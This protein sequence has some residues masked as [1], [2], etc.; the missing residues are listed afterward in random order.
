MK[1]LI[2]A[3]KEFVDIITSKRFIALLIAMIIFFLMS[4]LQTFSATRISMGTA[5]GFF[6]GSG[7]AFI[8]GIFG[9]ALGFDL[10]T[11]EKESGTLRTLLTHPLFRDEIIIGKTIAGFLAICLAVFVTMLFMLGAMVMRYIPSFDE[12]LSLAKLMLVTIAYLFTFFSISFLV[13][14]TVKSSSTSLTIA[15]GIF[16][17]LGL[18]IPMFGS[19]IAQSL[20]GQPPVEPL[21]LREGQT[22]RNA[23]DPRWSSYMEEMRSYREKVQSINSA[24]SMI[25]PVSSYTTIVNSLTAE[26]M[27]RTVDITKNIISFLIIP[28]VL[29]GIAYFR[30]T[31]EEL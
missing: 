2:V 1:A 9:I 19:L 10:I 23:S 14:A 24:I 17:V 27:F 11:R 29:F 31:R 7:I 12:I 18:L 22:F 13:S 5:I 6:G 3:K 28:V 8:G 15:I 20:A 30:F 16:I 21:D 4:V 26:T 25:S